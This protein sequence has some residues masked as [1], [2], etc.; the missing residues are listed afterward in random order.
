M[1][2]SPDATKRR[3]RAEN[4]PQDKF[5]A[6]RDARKNK[7]RL[8]DYQVLEPFYQPE[9]VHC[10]WSFTLPILLLTSGQG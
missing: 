9:R 8:Q 5:K 7:S 2:T 3:K 6:L 10:I 4:A 1:P